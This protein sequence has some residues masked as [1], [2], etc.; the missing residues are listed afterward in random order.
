MTDPVSKRQLWSIVSSAKDGRAIVLTSHDLHETEVLCQSIGMM[1]HGELRALGSALHLKNKFASGYRLVVDFDPRRT[2]GSQLDEG[3]L[4]ALPDAVT[5]LDV[6]NVFTK[7][8]EYRLTAPSAAVPAVFGAMLQHAA[9]LGVDA[10]A[11]SNL[12][13][14]SVFEKVFHDSRL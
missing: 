1:A 3:L 12:G 8:R 11:I 10:W 6:T 7:S 5:A 13:L 14:E 9:Q 4:S 2:T